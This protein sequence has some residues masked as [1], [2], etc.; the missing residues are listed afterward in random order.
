MLSAEHEALITLFR[1]RPSLAAELLCDALDVAV[2]EYR[3][4]R[5]ESG[6]LTEL[7][8]TEYRADAV[9]VLAKKDPV[10]AVVVEVQRGRDAVKRW[11]WPVYV[12]SLRARLRCPAVLLVIC[13]EARSANWCATPFEIGHPG[14]SMRPS[15]VGQHTVP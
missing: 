7:M 11:S 2:P 8:P 13:K 6:E 3:E 10:L 15:V 12:T 5:I 9:V 1:N 4:A 14:M